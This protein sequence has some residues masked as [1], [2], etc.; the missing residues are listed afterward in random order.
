MNVELVYITLVG[1][2]QF[3]M[4]I[5]KQED[6]SQMSSLYQS[7]RASTTITIDSKKDELNFL[8]IETNAKIESFEQEK[9]K[10]IMQLDG[11]EN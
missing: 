6:R 7:S 5:D 9:F 10:K 2:C 3:Y 1:I 11:I 8:E 4:D